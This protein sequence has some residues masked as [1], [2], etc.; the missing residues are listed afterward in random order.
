MFS[1][2]FETN[3]LCKNSKRSKESTRSIFARA[4]LE[5]SAAS[6]RVFEASPTRDARGTPSR[7]TNDLFPRAHSD[8]EGDRVRR[9]AHVRAS[10]RGAL[11]GRGIR[12][13]RAERSTISPTWFPGNFLSAADRLGRTERHGRPRDADSRGVVREVRVCGAAGA[14]AES[15]TDRRGREG[16]EEPMGASPRRARADAVRT[17]AF[18]KKPKRTLESAFRSTKKRSTKKTARARFFSRER[19]S[20]A[21]L[22]A[23]RASLD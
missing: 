12:S 23:A 14:R 20:R 9:C 21:R 6:K 19:P 7:A 22:V 3:N 16:P 15:A 11:A 10:G 2:F 1:C 17:P 8:L 18:S 4:D 13:R 5:Q